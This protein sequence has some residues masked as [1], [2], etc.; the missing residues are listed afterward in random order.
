MAFFHFN[1]ESWLNGITSPF[2]LGFLYSRSNDPK[3]FTEGPEENAHHQEYQH[4][5]YSR[6]GIKSPTYCAEYDY[7]SLGLVLL[8]IGL[9]MPL[10][11]ILK[12]LK[13]KSLLWVGRKL[14][15]SRRIL[16][17][18]RSEKRRLDPFSPVRRVAERAGLFRMPVLG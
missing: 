15:G 17:V 7:Y 8:E 3:G 4:P 5:N 18:K 6:K 12:S 1:N 13:L 16:A 11:M 14:L 9:W 10:D 2:F